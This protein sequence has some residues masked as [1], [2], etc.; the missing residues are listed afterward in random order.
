MNKSYITA[1]IIALLVAVWLI[2]GQFGD[3]AK[4]PPAAE[5]LARV[6]ETEIK[7]VKVQTV[8]SRAEPRKQVLTARGITEAVRKAMVRAETMGPIQRLPVEKG[9]RVK[10]GAVL[11]ELA[12]REREA[13]L[14]QAEATMRQR[15]LEYQASVKL[16]EK[17]HRSET[18]VA[19]TEAMYDGAK[20]MVKQMQIELANTKIRAP[21]DGVVED[22]P[23]EEGEYMQPGAICAV[24]VDDSSFLVTTQ[25]SEADI[26]H[27]TVGDKGH[28]TLTTGEEMDGEIRFIAKTAN[29]ATRTFL[30]EVEVV[31]TEHTLRE[32]VTASMHLPSKEVAAHRVPASILTLNAEGQMGLRVIDPGNV[33]RFAPVQIIDESDDGVWVTGLAASEEVISA[34]QGFVRDGATVIV[35]RV[36]SF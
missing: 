25:V 12:V 19:A 24:L 31:D 16:A 27:L 20:A 30:V 13:R 15:E 23:Q 7:P 8:A 18:A 17:G 36:D 4:Q 6:N 26:G 3:A 29:P 1:I 9:A 5:P 10:K 11:C 35:E 22:L 14:R 21:F 34:G 32:G 2:S 33:V 28:V